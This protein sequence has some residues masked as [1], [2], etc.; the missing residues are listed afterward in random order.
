M[1]GENGVK[2]GGA[3]HFCQQVTWLHYSSGCPDRTLR[4]E[5]DYIIQRIVQHH[6]ETDALARLDALRNNEAILQ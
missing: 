6:R 3:E 1:V 5:Q 2:K 4:R